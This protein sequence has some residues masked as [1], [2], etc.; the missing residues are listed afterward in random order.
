MGKHIHKLFEI[1]TLYRKDQPAKVELMKCADCGEVNKQGMD[2]LQERENSIFE[3]YG[4]KS[5][6]IIWNPKTKWVEQKSYR[7]RQELEANGVWQKAK[8][9]KEK[10]GKSEGI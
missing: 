2:I 9:N 3:M 5:P 7:H 8:N 1:Y 6:Y 4:K 10:I